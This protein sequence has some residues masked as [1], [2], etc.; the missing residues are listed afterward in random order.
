MSDLMEA[1]TLRSHSSPRTCI[2]LNGRQVKREIE[3]EEERKRECTNV[4]LAF[5][6]R[7]N[8]FHILN[9]SAAV[10]AAAASSFVYSIS[11]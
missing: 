10:A 6:S 4:A 7:S 2:Y 9:L 11:N 3:I 5:G 1:N 8:R